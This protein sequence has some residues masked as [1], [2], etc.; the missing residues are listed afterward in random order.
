MPKTESGCNHFT[1]GR[2]GVICLGQVLGQG[3]IAMQQKRINAEPTIPGASLPTVQ[4]APIHV[5]G[6]IARRHILDE[7]FVAPKL[8]PQ[9]PINDHIRQGQ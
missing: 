6:L 4:L 8:F 5:G 7:G 2:W 3:L 1:L 9:T